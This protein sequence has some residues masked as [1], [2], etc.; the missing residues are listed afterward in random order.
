M[1]GKNRIV[2][3]SRRKNKKIK[4]KNRKDPERDWEL[5][6]NKKEEEVEPGILTPTS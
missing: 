4:G 3:R 5:E 2:R 6:W 1:R